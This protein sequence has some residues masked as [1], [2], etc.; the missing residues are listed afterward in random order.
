MIEADE[1]KLGSKSEL[2]DTESDSRNSEVV[3]Y[4]KLHYSM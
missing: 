4:P 1:T 3:Y 2:K